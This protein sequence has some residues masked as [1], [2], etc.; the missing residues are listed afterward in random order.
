MNLKEKTIK[1]M[2]W[3]GIAQAG[4]LT[5]QFITTAILAH[6]LSPGDFGLVA[7]A[8]V[9][10][11]FANIIGEMGI[12][13]AL[14]QKQDATD[15]HYSSAFWLNIIVGV[16]LM[17]LMMILS[18]FV[19]WFYKKPELTLILMALSVNFVFASFTIIQQALLKKEMEF[20]TLA[21]ISIVATVFASVTSIYFAYRGHGVWSLIYQ[22]LTFTFL[23]ALLLWGI[24][25]WRPKLIFSLAHIKDIYRFSLNL[26]GSSVINYFARNID[27]LLIGKFLDVQSLGFYSIAYKIMMYPLYHVAWIINQVMFPVFSKL[28][29]DSKR[30]YNIYKQ[31]MKAVSLLAVPLMAGFFVIAPEFVQAVYGE[32]WTPVAFLIRVFCASGMIQ[33]IA[34]ISTTVCVACGKTSF[35][36]KT[37]IINTVLTFIVIFTGLRWGING[38]AFSYSVYSFLWAHVFIFAVSQILNTKFFA[39]YSNL[40]PAYFF[41]AITVTVMFLLKYYFNFS[42]L[43]GISLFALIGG[44]IYVALLFGVKL[45]TVKEKRLAFNL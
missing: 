2:L 31:A 19:A 29:G 24:S 4:K 5:A 15:D 3:S 26:T 37:D 11:E 18:S 44:S 16:F 34:S 32:K 7:L 21:V 8:L 28:Q 22:S 27:K 13:S 20:K 6:L 14:I 17:L 25:Q 40:F 33:S 38:V 10:T 43:K 45:I 36:L 41:S 30:L 42:G 35:K 1:G 39:F 9:F 12:S 23:N